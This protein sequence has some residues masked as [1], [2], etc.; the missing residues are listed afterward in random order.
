MLDMRQCNLA[1]GMIS[2]AVHRWC[3]RNRTYA[4]IMP[5]APRLA[6]TNLATRK[7]AEYFFLVNRNSQLVKSLLL[8]LQ[9][10]LLYR[11]VCCVTVVLNFTR[12]MCCFYPELGYWFYS[13]YTAYFFY[14]PNRSS[15]LWKCEVRLCEFFYGCILC[16]ISVRHRMREQHT[17]HAGIIWQWV[18]FIIVAFAFRAR[19]LKALKALRMLGF[20]CCELA[21]TRGTKTAHAKFWAVIDWYLPTPSFYVWYFYCEWLTIYLRIIIFPFNLKQWNWNGTYVSL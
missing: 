15:E 20:Y 21:E 17:M 9:C 19:I 4:N 11:I 12:T 3:L 14:K 7:F 16:T 1:L 6:P 10:V 18:L 13:Y 8:L 2:A 5:L